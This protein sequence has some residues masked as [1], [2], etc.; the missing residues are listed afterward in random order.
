[1]DN[2]LSA[3]DQY[4]ELM[5]RIRS[6][7][8]IIDQIREGGRFD[9][10]AMETV[11]FHLRKVIEGI[12][13]GCLVAVQNGL[14]AI[15]RDASGQWN[16]D[17]IFAR[18]QKRDQL[19]LPNP[20]FIR[21]PETDQEKVGKFVIQGE[22]DKCLTVDELRSEYRNLHG[23]LHELNPYVHDAGEFVRKKTNEVW[24]A[25]DRIH[26]MLASHL[27]G[28]NGEVFF[29][30]LRDKQDGLTKVFAASKIPDEEAA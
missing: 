15:P 21:S 29:C 18:L 3:K 30:T 26:K 23:W 6:R 5:S 8:D 9:Q 10:S 1:M 13:Y 19:P 20:S 7:L 17:N 28:I 12:A 4:L 25:V 27:I 22:P 16:A 11:A 24:I 2:Q 14:K